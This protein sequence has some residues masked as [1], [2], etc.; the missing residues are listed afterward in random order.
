MAGHVEGGREVDSETQES[1]AF[2]LLQLAILLWMVLVSANTDPARAADPQP[3]VA[4]VNFKDHIRPI[5]AKHCFGCHGAEGARAD[6]D[7][8]RYAS[9]LAGGSSG[10]VLAAEDPGQSRLYLL[11][12]HLEQPNM[13]LK[14]AQLPR[15][16]RDRIKQWIEGG[17]LATATSQ[18][19]K[20]GGARSVLSLQL[21]PRVPP[22]GGPP[23][24]SDLPAQPLRATRRANAVVALAGSPWAPLIA[25][26]GPGQVVLYHAEQR[27][28]IGILP[29]AEGLP[30][31]LKFTADGERLLAAGGAAGTSGSVVLWNVIS[32]RREVEIDGS[33]DVIVAADINRERTQ[34]ALGDDRFLKVYR[35]ADAQ[36]I[37]KIDRHTDWIFATG[38][39]PDGSRLAVADRSGGLT[40][41]DTQRWVALEDLKGHRGAVTSLAWRRD[42]RV[43]ASS[44]EDGTIR[45]W[46]VVRGERIR[47][48]SAHP[49]GV[50]W[51]TFGRRGELASVGRDRNLRTW[52][53]TGA[54][55][56]TLEPVFADIATRVAFVDESTQLVAGDW[57]GRLRIWSTEDGALR[58][59]LPAPRVASDR[60]R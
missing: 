30:H 20:G 60:D 33:E 59:P 37:K 10:K 51:V 28:R 6:L 56:Q 35:V 55:G 40:L 15:G 39:S 53:Q 9:V 11:V 36:L 17:L 38:F 2:G 5:F 31:L 48:W 12:T 14:R 41:W 18:P 24:P 13:P 22:A 42:G 27:R 29:F 32:G 21:P 43:L 46:D 19:L 58:G 26:G 3:S 25:V 1:T 16:D 47:S 7:L 57:T 8:T 44:G 4:R 52:D 34:I 50:L 45:L 49:P 23:L 54:P